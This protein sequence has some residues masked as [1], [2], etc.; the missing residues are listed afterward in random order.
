VGPLLK[1]FSL[2]FALTW[3]CW[4]GVMAMRGGSASADPPRAAFRS[5]LIYLGV[6]APAL[7]ALALTAR[8]EGRAGA[9]A[10]LARLVQW[11][12]GPRWYVF[13][14]TYIAAIKLVVALVHR[15]AAGAW[16]RFGDEPWYVMLVGLILS[17]PVQAGEEIGWRGYALPRLAVRMGLGG[18]SVVLGVLWA[19]WHLPLFFMPVSDTF[20]QSFPVYVLQV[21][22][23]S[24]AIAWLYGNTKGS[25]LLAM[26]LHAAINNTKDIVP[27]VVPGATNPLALSTS[28]VAWLTVALLWICAAYF[29]LRMPRSELPPRPGG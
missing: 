9:S 8:A 6:F 27:S 25:L 13:A 29:L 24:V 7:V 21:T 2:T 23:M 16:P 26:L 14:V 12:V 3:T 1:F 22:A 17:T 18:G 5:V 28:L 4:F 19:L 15:A 20:G 11:R 10:L